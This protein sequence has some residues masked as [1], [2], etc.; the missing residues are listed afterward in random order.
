MHR[1]YDGGEHRAAAR[2]DGPGSGD[3]AAG[4]PPRSAT[5]SSPPPATR[6]SAPTT[7]PASPRSSPRSPT[8]PRTRAAP[9]DAAHLLHAR[10]GDRRG[11]DALR[12]RALRRVLRLHH[13]RQR[14]RRAAGRDVHRRRGQLTIHGVDIHPGFAKDVLVNAARLAAQIV[15][16]LPSDRLTPETTEGREGYIHPYAIA[17]DAQ[18][19]TVTAIVRD[20][21]DDL[22][23]E[24]IDADP[25]DRR[26]GRG[27]RAARAARG[28]RPPPVPQHALASR[29]VPGGGERRRARDRAPRGWSHDAR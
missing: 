22:L 23:A 12:R 15:A 11:R 29:A 24:H 8:S 9:P 7:R 18:R 4:W 21:D 3:H 10:R 5:T 28:R 16:A 25:H 19:S 6:C 1:D 2:R 20:F 13:G 27:A 17:G 14:D 26:G